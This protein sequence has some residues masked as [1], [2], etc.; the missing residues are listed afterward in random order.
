MRNTLFIRVYIHYY[1]KCE[2]ISR[3]TLKENMFKLELLSEERLK[4]L[5]RTTT[6][7]SCIKMCSILD[8]KNPTYFQ[9]P[10]VVDFFN[11]IGVCTLFR[12]T[13]VKPRT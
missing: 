7:G 10:Y 11:K 6:E 4:F 13:K 9:N 3:N 5:C 2:E 8:A 12:K 1:R